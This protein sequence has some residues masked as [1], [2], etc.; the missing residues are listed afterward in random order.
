MSITYKLFDCVVT[1]AFLNGRFGSLK[2]H[3]NNRYSAI[4][5][6]TK[7]ALFSLTWLYA[8]YGL[9]E[10][11]SL[12]AQ[13]CSAFSGA[14]LCAGNMSWV[15]LTPLALA[16]LVSVRGFGELIGGGE[17]ETYEK[18]AWFED[19]VIRILPGSNQ[20]L[21]FML[22]ATH[23]MAQVAITVSACSVAYFAGGYLAMG[24]AAYTVFDTLCKMQLLSQPLQ[25]IDARITQGLNGVLFL[26]SY[27]VETIFLGLRM[28]RDAIFDVNIQPLVG[29]DSYF[30]FERVDL[31][32]THD[33]TPHSQDRL[34]E[35]INTIA[36]EKTHIRP[37]TLPR[38]VGNIQLDQIDFAR[39][40]KDLWEEMEGHLESRIVAREIANENFIY[41]DWR[42][43][44]AD[45]F[46]LQKE[47]LRAGHKMCIQTLAS[48]RRAGDSR[49]E[50]L[51]KAA[52]AAV[53]HQTGRAGQL[54]KHSF[55]VTLGITGHFCPT[56]KGE[57]IDS[58]V[59]GYLSE[60]ADELP[61]KI[62]GVLRN[63]RSELFQEHFVGK[64]LQEHRNEFG[65]RGACDLANVHYKY[66]LVYIAGLDLGLH[67]H[68]GAHN[69]VKEFGNDTIRAVQGAYERTRCGPSARAA[70][71]AA[72]STQC[73]IETIQENIASQN[74]GTLKLAEV[75][76]WFVDW[77]VDKKIVQ[78][79]QA[80]QD[81]IRLIQAQITSKLPEIDESAE[82]DSPVASTE[83]PTVRAASL[84]AD[85]IQP[86]KA[87]KD[88]RFVDALTFEHYNNKANPNFPRAYLLAKA[89][90]QFQDE[91]CDFLDDEC[92]KLA[93]EKTWIATMLAEMGFFKNT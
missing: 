23:P 25:H 29:F 11:G 78:L 28:I 72:Y 1:T 61:T 49:Q 10:A 80:D 34:I 39:Q 87:A 26:D 71:E 5:N 70:F 15:W 44:R 31:T 68:W 62:E 8:Q 16:I 51:A 93:P 69:E 81:E 90:V 55:L 85:K 19:H 9:I 73:I 89:R 30:S 77:L 91:G 65:P 67:E 32:K 59:S 75:E 2:N 53:A 63:K 37:A 18:A 82:E 83:D 76:A 64:L 66:A 40:V 58:L 13:A 35:D 42:R 56:R 21:Q 12:T 57:G 54:A 4:A 50:D 86:N 3:A 33:I 43:G 52:A 17:N 24:L 7:G 79:D 88:R 46:E 22:F 27:S 41:T 38:S 36:I 74:N 47:F 14:L 45:S 60:S 6:I 20:L 48:Q 84:L 92:T